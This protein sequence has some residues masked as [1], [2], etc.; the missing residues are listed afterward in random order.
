M[1][2]STSTASATRPA[3]RRPGTAAPPRLRRR[4]GT[5]CSRAG[6]RKVHWSGFAPELLILLVVVRGVG[7]FL[8]GWMGVGVGRRSHAK[9][10]DWIRLDSIRHY[11]ACNRRE[12]FNFLRRRRARACTETWAELAWKFRGDARHVAH[13]LAELACCRCRWT[14]L[15]IS[16]SCLVL[17]YHFLFINFFCG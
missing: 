2:R 16:C 4:P 10:V 17:N 7:P 13:V 14:C 15:R 6:P 9:P 3:I 11:V 5:D 1:C 12:A 8:S